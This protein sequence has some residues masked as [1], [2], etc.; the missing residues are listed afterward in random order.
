MKCYAS[1]NVIKSRISL[2]Y[3][4]YKLSSR[5]PHNLKLA[6]FSPSCKEISLKLPSLSR[7]SSAVNI[8]N[9]YNGRY[10][11]DPKYSNT[12]CEYK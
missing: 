8:N 9:D 7:A 3:A 11:C 12:R 5:F 4:F 1:K 2:Q 10:L 6:K